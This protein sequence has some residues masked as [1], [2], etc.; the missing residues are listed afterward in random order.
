MPIREFVDSNGVRWRVWD[1]TPDRMHPAI[2]SEPSLGEYREGWL[3][4]ESESE[5]RR[6][7][8]VPS[9]WERLSEAELTS[10]LEASQPVTHRGQAQSRR[11]ANAPVADPG[12]AA[13]QPLRPDEGRMTPPSEMEAIAGRRRIFSEPGGRVVTVCVQRLPAPTPPPGGQLT[14]SPGAVL[15][16][17]T[18]DKRT[19][20]LERWPDDWE[21][22][23]KERLIELFLHAQRESAGESSPRDADRLS[24]PSVAE[25]QTDAPLPPYRR[26]SDADR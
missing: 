3:T 13:K 15:R 1:V 7:A 11:A 23:P 9:D 26:A 10:L 21:R 4:F 18:D 20:D 24:L 5:R 19:F 2:A 25:R 6:H 22:L 14:A 8:R 17:R 16:F 12:A